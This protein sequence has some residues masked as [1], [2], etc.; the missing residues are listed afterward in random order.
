[1]VERVIARLKQHRAIATRYGKLAVSYVVSRVG[2]PQYGDG[3]IGPGLGFD[4]TVSLAMCRTATA[5]WPA[6]KL[7]G[8]RP[9]LSGTC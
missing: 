1:V 5:P 4:R 9:A 7:E 6:A 3:P 8:A 2:V